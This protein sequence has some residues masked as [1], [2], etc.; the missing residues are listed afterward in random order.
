[1]AIVKGYGAVI[2]GDKGFRC[3]HASVEA[4]HL[5][6]WDQTSAL[7]LEDRYGVPVYSNLQAMLAMHKAPE[8]QPEL[9][10]AHFAA[11]R[12]GSTWVT[13]WAG[14]SGGSAYAAGGL[15]GGGGG[16]W[17]APMNVTSVTV[18]PPHQGGKTAAA[19]KAAAVPCNGCNLQ[20]CAT[21]QLLC[22]SCQ[23][24]DDAKYQAPTPSVAGA[25]APA[26]KQPASVT[27]IDAVAQ[28]HARREAWAKASGSL[29]AATETLSAVNK[30]AVEQMR[31]L[32]EYITK[33][34]GDEPKA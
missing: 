28:L 34:C 2:E 5:P 30:R 18:N 11:A 9:R 4:L 10:D 6:Y 31:E 27:G 19:M 13:T 24:L 33:T 22:A 3:S 7:A 15:V 12:G 20:A 32:A 21:N 25:V 16:S 23:A 1:V 14:G 26:H 8:G 17:S 29:K